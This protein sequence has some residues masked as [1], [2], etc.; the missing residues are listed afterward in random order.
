MRENDI[1]L[2]TICY[3]NIHIL[4]NIQLLVY[5]FL[6]LFQKVIDYLKSDVERFEWSALEAMFSE[7]FLSKYVKQIGIEYHNHYI[8]KH[9]RQ[10]IEVLVKLEE[11]GFRKWK[12]HWNMNCLK[13][14]EKH[15]YVA[16]CYEVYYVNIHFL[17]LL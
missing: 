8:K 2:E 5:Y 9:V 10:Y 7:G 3:I 13:E 15:L 12:V 11:L 17:K 16:Y 6:C 1:A 14:T 4:L